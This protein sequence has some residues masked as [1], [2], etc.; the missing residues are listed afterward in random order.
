MSGVRVRSGF[1]LDLD[2]P[3][4][5]SKPGLQS[6]VRKE[7]SS[8]S[9][10]CVFAA[11]DLSGV[12]GASQS[13]SNWPRIFAKNISGSSKAVDALEMLPLSLL[14]SWAQGA[15]SALHLL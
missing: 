9:E 8:V 10:A 4:A 2:P 15:V 3:G 12:V 14:A 6:A 11:N 7:S 13:M 5:L 1:F